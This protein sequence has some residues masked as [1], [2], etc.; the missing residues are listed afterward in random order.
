MEANRQGV[1]DEGAE[2]N[3]DVNEVRCC[4]KKVKEDSKALGSHSGTVDVLLLLFFFFF[5]FCTRVEMS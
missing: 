2:A 4:T 5:F 3:V 1:I